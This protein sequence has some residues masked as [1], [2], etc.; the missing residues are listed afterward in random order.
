[1]KEDI[2]IEIAPAFIESLQSRLTRWYDLEGTLHRCEVD[3]EYLWWPDY[4]MAK[5]AILMNPENIMHDGRP[6]KCAYIKHFRQVDDMNDN[7]ILDWC[8]D[9]SEFV[10]VTVVRNR[11]NPSRFLIT[12][13]EIVETYSSEWRYEENDSYDAWE[14]KQIAQCEAENAIAA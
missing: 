14:A 6:G 1:M 11:F 7:P 4:E 13:I 3:P 5:A 8:C 12:R 10:E 9:A 2:V